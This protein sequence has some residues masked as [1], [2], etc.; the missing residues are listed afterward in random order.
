MIEFLKT[1]K[2][3]CQVEDLHKGGAYTVFRW[4]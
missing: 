1:L 3:N 2:S 4:K